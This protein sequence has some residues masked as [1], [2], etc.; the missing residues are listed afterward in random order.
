LTQRTI[1]PKLPLKGIFGT[2]F[3]FETDD[4]QLDFNTIELD[5]FEDSD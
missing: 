3:A 2:Y 4:N 5:N 1:H